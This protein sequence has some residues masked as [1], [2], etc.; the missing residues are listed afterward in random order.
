MIGASVYVLFV[1]QPFLRFWPGGGPRRCSA[2]VRAVSTLLEI[3]DVKVVI[4]FPDWDMDEFQPFLRFW[5]PCD[6]MIR[7][8]FHHIVSTL[9]EILENVFR[10][11]IEITRQ[12]VFQPFLRFWS[13]M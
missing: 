8:V 1:F 5:V 12:Y 4:R 10:E 2:R 6:R 11:L 13:S 3:L 7:Y 9:L